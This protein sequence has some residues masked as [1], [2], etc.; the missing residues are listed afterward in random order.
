MSGKILVLGSTGTV[1]RPLV[2]ALR[3]K[4]E[5]VKAASRS[6]GP[7]DG[8]EGVIFEFGK[9]ETFDAAFDG[10]DRAFVLLPGGYTDPKGLL[11]PVIEA[12]AARG[13]KLVLQS[14]M[15]VDA[16][17]SIPYRQVE[18]ALE[19]AGTPYVIL[20]PNWFADNFHR[21]W[22]AAIDH[23][24]IAVPAADGRT[25]FIDARDIA[26]S[27]AAALTTSLFDGQIFTL[28][29]PEALSYAQAAALLSDVIGRPIAYRAVDDETFI[30]MLTGAGLGADYAGFIAS[31]FH[32]V[33]EGW[34]AAV[35]ADVET[36]TG[37]P[38]RALRTYAED[39]V[40]KLAG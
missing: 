30:A 15:G 19:G 26:E 14:A 24:E 35:T 40:G 34:T 33:R 2:K 11:L 23:G 32:P 3:E 9:L 10:V 27:A 7:V 4:G 18:L 6:G 5:T 28:T 17:D 39:H 20:R 31:I 16:D 29:G 8:A 21:I 1:G 37:T 36:L 38:P 25:S 12:A 22:K 13:I